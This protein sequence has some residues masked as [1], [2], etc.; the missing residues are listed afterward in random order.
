MRTRLVTSVVAVI[1]LLSGAVSAR[2]QTQVK[3][4]AQTRQGYNPT[5]T[6]VSK[7]T[8]YKRNPNALS[9]SEWWKASMPTLSK[10]NRTRTSTVTI[11]SDRVPLIEIWRKVDHRSLVHKPCGGDGLYVWPCRTCNETG[12]VK[13]WNPQTKKTELVTCDVCEGDGK[14]QQKDPVCA[15]TGFLHTCFICDGKGTT[16]RR[17]GNKF[18]Q[19]VTCPECKGSRLLPG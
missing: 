16:E 1:V 11:D 7:V 5:R 13:R 10:P 19:T 17:R 12:Q 3:P 6:K 8:S 9:D 2:T 15:G 14:I 18:K 4:A